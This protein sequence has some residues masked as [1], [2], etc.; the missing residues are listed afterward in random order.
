MVSTPATSSK[1]VST[2]PC[3]GCELPTQFRRLTPRDGLYT[4]LGRKRR[5]FTIT[6]KEFSKLHSS[7]SSMFGRLGRDQSRSRTWVT[8]KKPT[9]GIHP[10]TSLVE[11]GPDPWVI[12]IIR[13]CTIQIEIYTRPVT[14]VCFS[15]LSGSAHKFSMRFVDQ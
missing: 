10:H 7:S 5:P 9:A 1:C 2:P 15:K 8:P 6:S 12:P 13:T 4:Y 11:G 14:R 3:Y